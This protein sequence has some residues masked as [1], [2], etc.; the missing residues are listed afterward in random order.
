M[1]LN[2]YKVLGQS[3]SGTYEIIPIPTVSLTSNVATITTGLNHGLVA[4]DLFDISATNQAVLNIRAVTATVTAST[5]FTFPRTNANIGSTAQ[6]T[7]YL[8]RYSNGFG[9]T[10]T[11]KAK[12]SGVATLTTGTA[13]GASAGDWITVWINDTNF[14]GDAI[15]YDVPTSTT[16]RYVRV[17]SDVSSAAVTTGAFAAQRA[18]SV[19]T[20]PASTQAVCSTLVVSNNLTHAGYFSAYIVPS[21]TSATSPPDRTIIFHRIALNAGESYN[22][23]MGYTLNAG[24]KVVVRASHA[25]MYFNLFGTELS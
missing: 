17:G 18:I 23:T 3:T 2:N 16:L 4:G 20:V 15:V 1:A 13:H 21:G 6:T 25:G 10:V 8:Y 24:D 11:N 22:A 5:A 7:A 19:Y 9:N 12:A 14:D